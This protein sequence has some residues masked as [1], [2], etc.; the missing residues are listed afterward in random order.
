MRTT[1]YCIE[2]LLKNNP[3]FSFVQF[4][5]HFE[6]IFWIEAV[7]CITFDQEIYVLSKLVFKAT[8]KAHSHSCFTTWS[9]VGNILV[10][11]YFLPPFCLHGWLPHPSL[12]ILLTK[13][14]EDFALR[15]QLHKVVIIIDHVRV[16]TIS[17]HKVE[18]F[19]DISEQFRNEFFKVKQL[20]EFCHYQYSSSWNAMDTDG[21][22]GKILNE[23]LLETIQIAD[24]F[25]P[26]VVE[27]I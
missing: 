14:K 26:S 5:Q 19:D 16:F 22:A 2:I 12:E 8:P 11:Q 1:E 24:L 27:Q 20:W 13:F 7:H 6:A 4:Q 23:D 3:V 21:R 17:C 25:I 18:P 10:G 9:L 15:H